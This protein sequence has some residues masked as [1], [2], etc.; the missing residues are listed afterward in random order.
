ML[1]RRA[2]ETGGDERGAGSIYWHVD[3]VHP[4][5]HSKKNLSG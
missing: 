3:E 5:F 2:E 4:F 1:D